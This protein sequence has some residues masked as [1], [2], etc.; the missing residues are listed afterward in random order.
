MSAL[1]ELPLRS[2]GELQRA[3]RR[4]LRALAP[5]TPWL[6]P[7]LFVPGLGASRLRLLQAQ[8]W[9]AADRFDAGLW[10]PDDAGL[11]ADLYGQ[12]CEELTRRWQAP[13]E[14][15]R[16]LDTA[17]I[18]AVHAQAGCLPPG[19]ALL[20]EL[21]AQSQQQMADLNARG[22]T[23][24]LQ[25]Y[26]PLATQCSQ[27]PGWLGDPQFLPLAHAFAWD[28]SQ[29]PAQTAPALARHI[30]GLLAQDHLHQGPRRWQWPGAPGLAIVAE[31]AGLDLVR[32][33]LPLCAE[34]QVLAVYAVD[35]TPA[36]KPLLSA[37]WRAWRAAWPCSPPE[38]ASPL[39]SVPPWIRCSHRLA[40]QPASL[41]CGSAAE[42]C[43]AVLRDL[44]QRLLREP[45]TPLGQALAPAF[46]D[47][48]KRTTP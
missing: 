46:A 35:E 18:A 12:A 44:T 28:W 39:H 6:L 7:I 30:G 20:P 9:G 24:L 10:D 36:R 40:P 2:P 38:P 11:H 5:A 47:R 21:Q 42:L 23:G 27:G 8:S 48:F 3:A 1:P 37:G 4:Q 43:A 26:W 19:Q 17:A 34:G 16:D 13:R 31:N 32:A 25:A 29:P 41:E 22:W 14:L 15:L 33:A 45:A